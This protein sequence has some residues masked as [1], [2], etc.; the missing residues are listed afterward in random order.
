MNRFFA[1]LLLALAASLPLSAHAK[2]IPLL[3]NTGDEIF[4]IRD[5]PKYGDGF[6]AGYACKH[7]GVFGA[8]IWT[9]DCKIMAVNKAE[10]SVG[11]IDP[12]EAAE[13]SQKY[14]LSMRERNVWNHYGF[15]A[16]LLIMGGFGL[17]SRRS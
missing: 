10:F 15:A 17:I 4:E 2:G 16:I 3:F 14:P 1:C 12:A 8:D 9:W 5:A 13:L 7:L 11:A 6:S